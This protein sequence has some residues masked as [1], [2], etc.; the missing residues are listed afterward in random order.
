MNIT[1]PY[2]Y[3]TIEISSEKVGKIIRGRKDNR[4]FGLPSTFV[5]GITNRDVKLIFF[6]YFL[7]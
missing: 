1:V 5:V 7:E 6:S 3:D 2:P 4:V